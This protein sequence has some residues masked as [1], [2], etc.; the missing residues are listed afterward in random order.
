MVSMRHTM[1]ALPACMLALIPLPSLVD[2]L[3]PAAQ[4][5]ARQWSLEAFDS[6]AHVLLLSVL[7]HEGGLDEAP[8]VRSR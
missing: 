1:S 3:T 6:L 5:C 4:R 2:R 8:G 7:L